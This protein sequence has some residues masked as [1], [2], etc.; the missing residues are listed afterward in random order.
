MLFELLAARW[1]YVFLVPLLGLAEGAHAHPAEA[2][3]AWWSQWTITPFIVAATV[4]VLWVYARG[5]GR[6]G[7]WQ[8]IGFIAG[9]LLLFLALQS[10]LDALAGDSF[11]VHQLQHLAIHS[12][13]P[14][15]LALSAPAGPLIAGMPDWLRRS[16]Y[17]P[18]GSNGIVRT[19]FGLLSAPRVAAANFIAMALFWLLP[20]LRS[21]ERRVG[22]ECRL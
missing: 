12:L 17:A 21:E 11:A 10:P 14:M 4:A 9:T 7:L 2:E 16:V 20:P 19:T 22:K 6:A 13:V 3:A 15:L 18:L 8:R 5:A 1:R